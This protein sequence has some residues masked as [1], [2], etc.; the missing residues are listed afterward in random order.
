MSGN[1]TAKVPIV[2]IVHAPV[3]RAI[4]RARSFEHMQGESRKRQHRWNQ[5]KTIAESRS[6]EAPKENL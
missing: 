2:K 1:I 3:G 4:E 5:E 6:Q